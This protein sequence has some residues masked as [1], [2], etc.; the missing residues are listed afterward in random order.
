MCYAVDFQSHGVNHHVSSAIPD[1]ALD[2]ELRES[3]RFIQDL[4]GKDVFVFAYPYNV[5]SD[6]ANTLLKKHGYLF[7][8]A[9]ARK[10]NKIGTNQYG[11]NSIGIV[12]TWSNRDLRK[13]LLLAE[14]KT[15]RSP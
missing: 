15:L 11:L 6:N 3:K 14:L 13:A 8:R 5:V 1:E 10:Y 7:A 9:G 4:T 2:Y 12:P